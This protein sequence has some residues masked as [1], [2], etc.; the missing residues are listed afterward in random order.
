MSTY[1]EI[2]QKLSAVD[3]SN[4]IEKKGNLS[5]LSWAWAW[6]TLMEHYPEAEATF[7]HE[8]QVETDG[9]V[10]VWCEV[11][12][13]DC[14]RRMWLPVMNHRNDAIERPDA[15]EI[16]D[17]RMR[18]LVKCLAL[19]GLGFSLYAGEDVPQQRAKSTPP[20]ATLSEGNRE[21]LRIAA[22][23]KS[24]ELGDDSLPAKEVT[25]LCLESLGLKWGEVN[26]KNYGHLFSAIQEFEPGEAAA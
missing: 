11:R 10:T 12:I 3:V 17:T 14:V 18:C 6:G 13:G 7:D 20:K 16:S 1:G 2:W 8:P 24:T 25:K 15:R 19:F 22:E 26:D 21:K 23:M 5:Y 4:H 9:S